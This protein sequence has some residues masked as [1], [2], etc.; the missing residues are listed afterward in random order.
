MRAQIGLPLDGAELARFGV[1]DVLLDTTLAA[2]QQAVPGWQGPIRKDGD[3]EVW[4]NPAYTGE[5]RLLAGGRRAARP[6]GGDRA[7]RRRRPFAAATWDSEST[8]NRRRPRVDRRQRGRRGDRRGRVA[9]G[10]RR[11]VGRRLERRGRRSAPPLPGR[12]TASSSASSCRPAPGTPRS[13]T[14]RSTPGSAWRSAL[15]AS[16]WRR[17]GRRRRL[18][19]DPP[20]APTQRRPVPRLLPR[21]GRPPVAFTHGR[22]LLA[23]RSHL[24]PARG[25]AR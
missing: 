8:S 14:G 6:P 3:L 4:R 23:V 16:A 11:A 10:H 21:P 5:A 12:S 2:P 9:A 18:A 20:A 7:L 13:G 1:R 25:R 19:R 22:R 24:R 15:P 17:S